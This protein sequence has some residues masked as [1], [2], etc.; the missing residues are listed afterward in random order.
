MGTDPARK[1]FVKSVDSVL[2]KIQVVDFVPGMCVLV[3]LSK[4]GREGLDEPNS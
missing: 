3:F 1:E 2:E 4:G